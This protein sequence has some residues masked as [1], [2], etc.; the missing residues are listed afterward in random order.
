MPILVI[1]PTRDPSQLLAAI[2][3]IDPALELRVWPE[4]GD[5]AEVRMVVSWNHPHGA[6]AGLRNLEV[7]ASYGAGI[8]HMLG[9]DQIPAAVRVVRFIDDDLVRHMQEYVATAILTHRRHWLA[10]H[11]QQRAGCWQQIGYEL[12]SAVLVLGLGR[13]GAAVAQTLAGLGLEVTGWSRRPKKL[14]R[15]RCVTGNHELHAALAQSD[16]LVCLL[17]LTDE[18]RGIL[19]RELF[20]RTKRGAYLVNVGRGAHL[21][22]EDL[23]QALQTGQLSGACLDVFASEPL[24]AEHPFWNHPRIT[25]TPH[26]ASL[27]NPA[28]IA[29]Q[30]VDNYHRMRRGEA[31]L[32]P[33]DLQRGY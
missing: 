19:G 17:P 9:D 6:L 3:S 15:F 22:A 31:L 21:V 30:I 20:T 4:C 28:S 5:P 14:D 7:V 13:L 11:H 24:P 1:M 16:Y 2:R 23:L 26:V 27:T 8:D 33:V 32:N 10:Y 29:A 25:L 18:T 12:T